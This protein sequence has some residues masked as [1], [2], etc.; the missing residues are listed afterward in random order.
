[1]IQARKRNNQNINELAE[2]PHGGFKITREEAE[3]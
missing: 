2:T 1:M 3:M